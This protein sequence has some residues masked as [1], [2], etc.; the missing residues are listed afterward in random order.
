MPLFIKTEKFN[1]EAWS[2]SPEDRKKYLKSHQAWVE[3]L[4]EQRFNISSGYLVDK[5]GNPGGGGLLVLE[6]RSF[7]E[8]NQIII[9]GPMILACLVEWNLQEWIKV[10]GNLI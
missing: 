5:E 2:L 3:G 7:D 1:K 6:A 4:K 10:S 9:K 8:A